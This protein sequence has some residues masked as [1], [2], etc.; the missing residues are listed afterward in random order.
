MPTIGYLAALSEAADRP[1]RAAFAKR[2][3]ELGWTEGSTAAAHHLT[4]MHCVAL[5]G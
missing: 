3:G 2:L 1:R 5:A 4:L